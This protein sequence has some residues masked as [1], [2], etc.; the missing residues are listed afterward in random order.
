MLKSLLARFRKKAAQQSS[1]VG[2]PS[3]MKVQS[4]DIND[5]LDENGNIR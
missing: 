5:V 4:T 2:P 3:S 1:G